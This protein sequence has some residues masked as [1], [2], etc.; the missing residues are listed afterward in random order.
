MNYPEKI[1]NY[2]KQA[3]ISLQESTALSEKIIMIK[4]RRLIENDQSISNIERASL[5]DLIK[6]DWFTKFYYYV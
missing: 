6:M 5:L 2:R 4:T 3:L 1:S